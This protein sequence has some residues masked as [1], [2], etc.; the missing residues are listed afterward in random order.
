MKNSNGSKSKTKK[1]CYNCKKTKSSEKS[2][3]KRELPQ[4]KKNM[5][6]KTHYPNDENVNLKI[7]YPKKFNTV[8]IGG[9]LGHLSQALYMNYHWVKNLQTDMF[10]IIVLKINRW[11]I[12]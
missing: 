2:V 12:V 8:Q 3:I 11:K 6:L 10:I 4:W 9:I 1:I 7:D 5:D